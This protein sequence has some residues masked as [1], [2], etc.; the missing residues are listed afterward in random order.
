MIQFGKKLLGFRNIQE[1]LENKVLQIHNDAKIGYRLKVIFD[2][3][4][5]LNFMEIPS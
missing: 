4:S 3:L 2:S 1:K 5:N